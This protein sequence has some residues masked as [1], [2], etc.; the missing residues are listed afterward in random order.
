LGKDFEGKRLDGT[1]IYNPCSG[2]KLIKPNLS[3]T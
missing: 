3:N 1:K 2:K